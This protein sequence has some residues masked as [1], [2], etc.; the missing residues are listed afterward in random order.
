M[1]RTRLF[2]AYLPCVLFGSAAVR[3]QDKLARPLLIDSHMHVW[4]DDAVRFPFAHP[5]NPTFVPPKIPAS[6]QILVKEM[7]DHGVRH[8]VLVQTISHGWD[9]S[10]LVHCLKRH[11]KRFRGQG[12][13][14][15]TDPNV[16]DKLEYW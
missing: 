11:P 6:L 12:L 2:L 14:D 16:A 10:Y 13:I 15:P 1:Q 9:N 8:C 3:A 5:Y 7:D 4:T